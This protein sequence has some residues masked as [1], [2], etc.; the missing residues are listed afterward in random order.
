MGDDVTGIKPLTLV[1]CIAFHFVV[2]DAELLVGVTGCEIQDKVV[3]ESV[4]CVVELGQ[5]GF[6]HVEFEGTRLDDE[7]EYENGEANKY[8]DCHQE[9]PEEAEKAATA[10]SG[11]HYILRILLPS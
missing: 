1:Q 8:D 2:V 3:S 6:R 4:V 5:L 9:F 10:V 7:P 11:T